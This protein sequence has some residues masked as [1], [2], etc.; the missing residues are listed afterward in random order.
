MKQNEK[1]AIS[2]YKIDINLQ[3]Y[4]FLKTIIKLKP[5]KTKILK[6]FELHNLFLHNTTSFINKIQEVFASNKD[7]QNLEMIVERFNS[8]IDIELFIFS[9]RLYEIKD[10]LL[11]EAKIQKDINVEKLK[12]INPLSL[13]Y[14]KISVCKPYTTRVYGAVLTLMFFEKLQQGD[15]NF[16]SQD[17]CEM[18]TAMANEMCKFQQI[19]LETN[20]IFM[21]VFIECLNQSIISDSGIDYET[22]ILSVLTKLGIKNISKEHDTADASMEFDFFFEFNDKTFGIGAKRTL[23]ERYKQFIHTSISSDID[24]MIEITLGI[25]LNE[26]KANII[27]HQYNTYIFVAD[28]IYNS[29]SY[30]Q[31][32]PMIFS[33]KDLSIKTLIKLSNINR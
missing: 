16:M 19:G 22:R 18:L 24:I 17:T 2:Q 28:E 29:K 8:D 33:V 31:N 30:L 20:Q 15:V 5:V 1:I 27:T 14:D 26:D 10:L 6:I 23:R 7:I 9:L 4:V 13:E 21:L 12:H 25:D 32:N 11:N 3:F